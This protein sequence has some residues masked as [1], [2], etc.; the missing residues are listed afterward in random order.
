M[1]DTGLDD[2]FVVEQCTQFGHDGRNSWVN[3]RDTNSRHM[4]N[5]LSSSAMGSVRMMISG[6]A[7]PECWSWP[8]ISA[9]PSRDSGDCVQ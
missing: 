6:R 9:L 7:E 8:L 1:T 3:T 5:R 4:P 2:E